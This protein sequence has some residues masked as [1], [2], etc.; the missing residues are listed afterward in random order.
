MKPLSSERGLAGAPVTEI[1]SQPA[2]KAK[3]PLP[4]ALGVPGGVYGG[5]RRRSNCPPMWRM[6]PRDAA[7][8]YGKQPRFG[9]PGRGRSR[10]GD[11]HGA[12]SDAQGPYVSGVL[13]SEGT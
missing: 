7:A 8:L 3:V 12:P 6:S 5:F 1:H 13:D 4:R 2:V 11:P 10:L 9:N